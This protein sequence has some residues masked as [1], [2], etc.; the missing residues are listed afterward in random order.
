MRG[1][2]IPWLWLGIKFP[3][4]LLITTK[5]YGPAAAYLYIAGQMGLK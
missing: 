1:A 3:H 2:C 5:R 4:K